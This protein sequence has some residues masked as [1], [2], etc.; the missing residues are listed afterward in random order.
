[1]TDDV[2]LTQAAHDQLVGLVE[3]LIEISIWQ[4]AEAKAK[5]PIK[6]TG[7]SI[8]TNKLKLILNTL[9]NES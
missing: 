8:M 4:D 1:M 7:E 9:K 3:Q 6:N 5:D 2:I